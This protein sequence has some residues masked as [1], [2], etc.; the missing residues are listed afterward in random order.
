M[1]NAVKKSKKVVIIGAG[2][3]GLTAAYELC[4]A[5]IESVVLEKD[6]MVGGLARTLNHNGYYFD[7]G[8][9][10]FFTKVKVVEDMW[11]KVLGEDFL[12]RSRLSRIYYNRKYFYYPLRA[13]NALSGLGA[14]N[15]FLILL[16]YLKSRLFPDK[17]EETFEQWISNRFGKR[18]YKTFFK[19]YTEKVWGI[20]C[21]EIRAE[22]AAQRIKGLSLIAALKNALLDQKNSHK[23]AIIRT[24]IDS[25]HYPKLGPGMMWERVADIVQQDSSEVRLGSEV[26][27][28]FWT[29]DRI[30]SL[31]ITNNEQMEL[32]EGTHFISSMPI[33]EL[34]QKFE[35]TVPEKVLKAAMDL[36][37]R[38]FLTVILVIDKRDLFPDNW[39]YIH[40]PNVKIGRIQNFKNWSP[41][42]VPDQNKTCLGLEYFCFEGDG[43]WSMSNQELI[44]LGK[45]ELDILGLARASDI[46]DGTVIRMAKAYPVY[47]ST[48]Q[49]SLQVIR[50]FLSQIDN[51]HLVGRNGMHKYNNQD[52]SMLTAMLAVKNILGANYNLWQ[53]NT[54]QEYQ[55]EIRGGDGKALDEFA[56]LAST[57]PQIPERSMARIERPA[58][59]EVI[60]RAFARIDKLA[61]AIALGSV[62]GLAIFIATLLLIIEGGK[63]ADRNLQLLSQYFI[64]YTITV[65][66]AF[67]GMGYSFFWGF[68]W[69][70]LFAYLRNLSLGYLI[71]RAKS[72]AESS[73]FR[74]LMDYI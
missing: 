69:G 39:I 18:L 2:P 60:I 6:N 63:V 4:K 51:L 25:F 20:P 48:Y 65:K 5:G 53:V 14:W 74:N 40:D 12:S 35:P 31:E 50:Q 47:D 41:Y 46:Q 54:D 67:I 42:M 38:D 68:I 62:W 21:S 44:E 1:E 52:H 57:Q 3:A 23:G 8:G 33:R 26:N 58:Y 49:E 72:K 17:P 59:D 30:D 13:F 11:H 24:L 15:S 36:N 66:G 19:T 71:H 34:I 45:R 28:L 70:W 56:L 73:S 37:Y 32:I 29:G 9:H 43:L 7:M 61:L 10:R 22:W 27:R 16:S 64:G 55:E